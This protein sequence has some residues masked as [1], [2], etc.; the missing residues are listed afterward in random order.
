[1]TLP[2]AILAGGLATR[3]RPITEKIP[4]SLVEVAGEAFIVRQLDYLRRQRVRDVVLCIGYLGEMIEAV[5][6]DGSRFGLH[7]SYS[8][9]GPA[10]LG[11][12]GALRRAGPLLGEA[13]FVLY[14]D[15]YLPVDFGAI[16]TEFWASGQPALMTVL[17]NQDRWDKSNV[18]FVD[19][20]LQEYN[21]RAPRPDF[22]YIDYGLSIVRREILESY[23]A[24][25]AFDLAT[26]YHSL[27]LEQRLHGYEVFKRFYEIGSPSGLQEADELFRM[28]ETT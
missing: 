25:Q 24:N 10:L 5:V 20:K 6:G 8:M 2:V 15:S 14:G 13:C 7:V 21:K 16:E 4:K 26:V 28:G 18:L 17:Y 27:S 23:P 19:G 1:M 22:S 9:D 11:T 12:G 3:L